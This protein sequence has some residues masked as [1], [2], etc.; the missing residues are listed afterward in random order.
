MK[1]LVGDV[2]EMMIP[3]LPPELWSH[4]MTTFPY[5]KMAHMRMVDHYFLDLV[6]RVVIPLVDDFSEK[7]LSRMGSNETLV[8][9][10][11]LKTLTLLHTHNW[12]ISEDTIKNLTKI[13]NLVIGHIYYSSLAP[14]YLLKNITS[15]KIDQLIADVFLMQFTNLKTLSMIFNTRML[16]CIT[17]KSISLLTNL[18]SLRINRLGR[19][20]TLTGASLSLLTN[21]T[22]LNIPFYTPMNRKELTPLSNKLET[23]YVSDAFWMGDREL[24]VMTNLRVLGLSSCIGITGESLLGMPYLEM[25]GID[26]SHC[27]KDMVLQS[28]TG[29]KELHL[30]QEH[31]FTN[32]S[33]KGMTNLTTICIEGTSK[34]TSECR[35]H[36]PSLITFNQTI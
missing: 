7:S 10:T 28:L 11:S 3:P 15:L 18:T 19:M 33:F 27:V 14:F 2:I 31:A 34:I 29:L 8:Q 26:F 35:K 20:N 22:S 13:T 17:D 23:L 5:E 24:A 32:D 36:L 1:R 6:D 30:N 12:R 9:F 16:G 4:I 25:L 21:L